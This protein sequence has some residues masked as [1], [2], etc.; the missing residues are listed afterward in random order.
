M[1]PWR[2]GLLEKPKTLILDFINNE[3]Q[4]D[5]TIVPITESALLATSQEL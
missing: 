2:I 5:G 1:Y 4:V 3:E